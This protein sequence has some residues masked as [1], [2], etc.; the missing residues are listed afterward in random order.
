MKTFGVDEGECPLIPLFIGFNFTESESS[1]GGMNDDDGEGK[2]G[3]A[4]A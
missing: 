4:F 1:G 3:V 2:G